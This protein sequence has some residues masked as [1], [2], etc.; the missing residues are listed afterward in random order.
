MTSQVSVPRVDQAGRRDL[1]G[2]RPLAKR[3]V[4]RPAR[5]VARGEG[6][7]VARLGFSGTEAL[8]LLTD[9]RD[10]VVADAGRLRN[11]LHADLSVLVPGYKAQ[12]V[13]LAATVGRCAGALCGVCPPRGQEWLGPSVPPAA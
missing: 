13:R 9:Y 11:R 7:P 5:V 12:E 8:R 3:M 10:E 2:A 4:V 1:I 6:L